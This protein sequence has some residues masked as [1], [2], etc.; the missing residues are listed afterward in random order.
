MVSP[1]H[2]SEDTAYVN[3]NLAWL[4]GSTLRGF[5]IGTDLLL[6][7]TIVPYLTQPSQ[8]WPGW[9]IPF[10]MIVLSS[11]CFMLLKQ[12]Y[13]LAS[14]SFVIILIGGATAVLWVPGQNSLAC[15]LF[16]PIVLVSGSIHGTVGVF[17]TAGISSIA[18]LSARAMAG[19]YI[20]PMLMLTVLCLIWLTALTSWASTRILHTALR[21]AWA[22]RLQ[23]ARNLD[24]ARDYQ[25]KLAATLRQLEEATHRLE[26]ANYA[27]SWARA[28]AAEGRRIKA[29]FAAN[30]SH[31]LRTPLNLVVGFAELMLH[32]PETY[33][34]TPLPQAYQSDLGALYRN[35]THL[36][37]MVN[38]ILDLSQIDDGQMPVI[39]ELADIG[40]IVR[41]ATAIA[42]PLVA[43]K[44]LQLRMKVEPGLPLLSLDR[45][46][47]RQVL[48]NLISNA[49]RFTDSGGILVEARQEDANVVVEVTDTG[50]GISTQDL[51]KLF[52]PFH[53]LESSLTRGRGGTGLGLA[54]SKEF[55]SLHGGRI[56][57][58]SDGVR[59]KGSTFHFTL[60]LLPEDKP[61][62]ALTRDDPGQVRRGLSAPPGSYDHR[63][64]RRSGDRRP[65]SAPHDRLPHR[66]GREPH[67]R[68]RVGRQVAGSC[69]CDGSAE[70]GAACRLA[71]VSFR[72]G[73]AWPAT[74]GVSDA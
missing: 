6:F 14:A 18:I 22:D 21:W 48:L 19:V 30:V 16:L 60:P 47:I 70:V 69:Y 12:R 58:T 4:K 59:G 7:L 23:A 10:A 2:R 61:S 45:L 65:V 39:K 37:S 3:Q 1:M 52:Q 67:Q 15:L 66:V 46:R 44:N 51:N 32:N 34:G 41:E 42:S 33:G 62:L 53:Q 50:L 35:A 74:A 72:V 63:H 8:F 68:I 43:P 11:A 55:V 24:E 73:Q 64:G 49:V 26:R 40:A 38:D 5:L 29:Q 25:G 57:A 9:G 28:E 17:V 20:Q 71:C 54:V 31:E 56:W 27:L 36:E 13:S